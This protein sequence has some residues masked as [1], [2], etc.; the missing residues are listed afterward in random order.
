MIISWKE[1]RE[2]KNERKDKRKRGSKRGEEER[3]VTNVLHTR[4]YC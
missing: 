1:K 2:R 3:K 4:M